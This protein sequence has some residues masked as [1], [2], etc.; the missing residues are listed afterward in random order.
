M[1]VLLYKQTSSDACCWLSNLVQLHQQHTVYAYMCIIHNTWDTCIYLYMYIYII[2][3]PMYVYCMYIMVPALINVQ[4]IFSYLWLL[5]GD[6]HMEAIH[7]WDY[8]ILKYSHQACL[9]KIFCEKLAKYSI[10]FVIL[11][12]ICKTI[13]NV[14]ISI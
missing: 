9:F 8:F 14:S 4:I 7:H 12:M 10:I 13:Q 1:S 3:I 6:V 11:Y 5:Y 2:Y